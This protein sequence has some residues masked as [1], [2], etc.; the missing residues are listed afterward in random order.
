MTKHERIPDGLPLLCRVSRV[1]RE[2]DCSKSK[3]YKLINEGKLPTVIVDRSIRIRREEVLALCG[4]NSGSDDTAE[5]GSPSKDEASK[6]SDI[7]WASR[8][9]PLAKRKP[10]VSSAT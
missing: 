10:S 1:A 5:S 2:L 7:R 6:S 8:L 4:M 9:G 3:V